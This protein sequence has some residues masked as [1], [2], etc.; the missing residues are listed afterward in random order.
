MT[1]SPSEPCCQVTGKY[2]AQPPICKYHA[3]QG[4]FMNGKHTDIPYTAPCGCSWTSLAQHKLTTCPTHAIG[5]LACC[6]R[7]QVLQCVCAYAYSCPDHGT[8]H[9]GTHD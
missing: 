5:P 7:S 6:P 8:R 9:M 3:N 1:T 4:W 2:D